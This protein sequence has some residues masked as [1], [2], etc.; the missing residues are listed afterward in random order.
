MQPLG[1]GGFI[2]SLVI[3]EHGAIAVVLFA[4]PVAFLGAASTSM[5]LSMRALRHVRRGIRIHIT[6]LVASAPIAALSVYGLVSKPTYDLRGAF[7]FFWPFAV[8]ALIVA[9]LT[10]A[11]TFGG[12]NDDAT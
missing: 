12:S 5:F 6:T 7:G 10:D 8:A 1:G 11:A 4:T 2:A 9:I 3:A